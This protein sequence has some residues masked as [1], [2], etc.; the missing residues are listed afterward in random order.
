MTETSISKII[1]ITDE[2]KGIEAELSKMG[3]WNDAVGEF[4]KFQYTD[5]KRELL[6]ELL[7]ELI[8]SYVRLA[9]MN[10]TF[11]KFLAYLSS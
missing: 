4:M 8:K 7:I 1:G 3:S 6:K 11:L 5:M 9:D 2:I 10:S